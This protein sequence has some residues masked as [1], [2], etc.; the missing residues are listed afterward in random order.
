MA[1]FWLGVDGSMFVSSC[2]SDGGGSGVTE[3]LDGSASWIHS[4]PETHW[5][6][7]DLG[8]H[9]YITKI[10]GRSNSNNDP[11]SVYVWASKINGDWG[12]AIAEDITTW[13]NTSSWVEI[14]ST[15]KL[16]KFIKVE[17]PNIEDPRFPFEFGNAGSPFTIFDVKVSY[18]PPLEAGS[19]NGGGWR[20]LSLGGS[21]TALAIADLLFLYN[22]TY[23]TY[24]Q[25]TTTDN[26]ESSPLV[27]FWF[28]DWDYSAQNYVTSSTISSIK[29]YWNYQYFADIEVYYPI[30]SAGGS[31][32]VILMPMRRISL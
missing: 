21:Q 27:D 6:I 16:G 18:A 29:G 32:A 28:F 3:A 17:I 24:T 2:G 22:G 1:D 15:N 14:D 30:P 25:A 20:L 31:D 4:A 10:R 12:G 9:Y 26:E 5:F 23:Y 19:G 11:A 8:S 7:I 13:I